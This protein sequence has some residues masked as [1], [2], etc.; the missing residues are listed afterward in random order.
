MAGLAIRTDGRELNPALGSIGE[1]KNVIQHS[2]F[3]E[4]SLV[5]S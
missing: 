5:R 1:L 3:E 2:V 4:R